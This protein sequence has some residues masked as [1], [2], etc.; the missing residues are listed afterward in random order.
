MEN[1]NKQV[2]FSGKSKGALFG[3]LLILTGTLFLAFNF[4]W[5]NTELRYVLFSWP[6]IFVCFAFI[7][8]SKKEFMGMLFWLVLAAFFLLPRIATV[9][10]DALPGI[11]D[12][13]TRNFWPIL[14]IIVGV[15][16]IIRIFFRKRWSSFDKNRKHFNV[17]EIEGTDG[18]YVRKVVFGGREDIFLEPVFRGGQI[19][20]AF[21]G[22][23][24]DL[25]RSS[26]PEG[27]THLYINAVFGGVEIYLPDDW[28]VLPKVD[29]VLGG[30]ENKRFTK[31]VQSDTSR[32]LFIT[33]EV[34]FGGCEIR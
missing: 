16:V 7:A 20:V 6:M 26:L 5:L 31:N 13:F 17:N 30:V 21:G 34:V 15:G 11:D 9:Y 18:Y 19:E 12:N 14:L 33:G 3:F 10:P 27:D 4:G 8:I 29:A 28:T 2:N 23:E 32:K 1:N 24:L 22:V 25:R